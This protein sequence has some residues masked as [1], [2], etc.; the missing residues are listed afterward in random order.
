MFNLSNLR[1]TWGGLHGDVSCNLSTLA[2]VGGGR[3]NECKSNEGICGTETTRVD[4]RVCSR[5]NK[6]RRCLF[7]FFSNTK[8]GNCNENY[9]FPKRLLFRFFN[10]FKFYRKRKTTYTC[11][12]YQC[13][14]SQSS[15]RIQGSLLGIFKQTTTNQQLLRKRSKRN[16]LLLT[17]R[18]E[19]IA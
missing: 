14:N 9:L 16:R 12:E 10:N 8:I 11:L 18:N 15:R 7:Y 13:Y 17:T 2:R 5:H 4:R 3:L 6:F 1:F 19:V